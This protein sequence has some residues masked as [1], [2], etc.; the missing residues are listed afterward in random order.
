MITDLSDDFKDYLY[1]RAK[2]VVACVEIYSRSTE[3]ISSISS[4]GAA[5]ARFSN[6]CYNWSNSTGTYEYSAKITSFPS[7]N[8]YLTEQVNNA[9]ITLSNTKRGEG[10][11]SRFVLNNK[12]KGCWLVIR[13]LFPELPEESLIVWW[14]K[15][16]RPGRINNTEVVLEAT[17]EMGNYK[18]ELPLKTYSQPCP[19]TFGKDAC[20]GNQTLAE[21]SPAYQEAYANY[22][23]MGC[24]DRTS[25]TCAILSNTDY[26]QGQRLVAAT[27]QFSYVDPNAD[28][29]EVKRK[30]ISPVK[31]E[32][33]SSMN[34][35]DSTDVVPIAFGRCQ[36]AGHPFTWADTG[37][38]VKSLQAFCEGKISAFD[39]IR[40]RTYNI[41]ITQIVQ[42]LGDWGNVGTQ[43]LDTLFNGSSGYNSRLAYLELVTNG[44]SPTQV[45]DAPL[46]TAVIRGLEI[47]VPDPLG[48]Y[49]QVEY[50]NNPIHIVRYLLTD[51][52]YGRVPAYRMADA[53]HVIEAN[54]CDK[55]VEDRTQAESI[56][57]PTNEYNS[58]GVG[59]RRYRS[60]SRYTAYKDMWLRGE[61]GGE[62]PEFDEPEIRWFDPSAQYTVP[63]R[64]TVL[65]QLYTLN[66]A[67]QEKTS[68]LD[69][70]TK[71]LLPCFRGFISYNHH[72]EVEIR[73]RRPA[74]YSYIR[75]NVVAGDTN[76]PIINIAK[77]RSNFDG[78]LLIGVSSVNAEIRKVRGISYY[79]TSIPV[80]PTASGGLIATG[81][82]IDSGGFLID[83]LTG[84]TLTD[85]L[86]GESLTSGTS[87]TSPAI[88]YVDISGTVSDGAIIEL[89]IDSGSANFSV[90]YKCQG[91]ETL[92]SVTR[93]LT[94]YLNANPEFNSYLTAYILDE[95]PNRVW[96]RCEV[97]QL[98]LD[99]AIEFD[100]SSAEE[101]MRVQMVFENCGDLDST[102]SAQF[103]NIVADSFVWNDEYNDEI[104]AVSGKYT[105]AVDDFHLA[106]LLPRAAWDTIEL[107]GELNKE[108]LDLRFVDNYWQAAYITKA[109]AIEMIDG[110][111]PFTW[112]SGLSA[113]L[114]EMS[115]VVAVRHDSGDG[116]LNY[117]PVWITG[118]ELAIDTFQ[119]N[120]KGSLYFSSSFDFRVQPVEPLLTTTLNPDTAS[121]PP[122]L[123]TSGGSGTGSE[124]RYNPKSADYYREFQTSIYS[125][126]GNDNI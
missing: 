103:D 1:K 53:Q 97:G 30:K 9:T 73:T 52:R 80:I 115:D 16:L 67:L 110:N 81:V 27:G 99:R 28:P 82:T 15:C 102:S 43:T 96:I 39:F 113:L 49:T 3:D 68:L 62:F 117:L 54:Y 86:T 40:S 17:Q 4:P 23:T 38:E 31:T 10:S 121:V 2:Y 75:T 60:A 48:D 64:Q 94:A 46:V 34:D 90:G 56:L 89:S 105:S 91:I 18:V 120:L 8:K 22:G 37:T 36:L 87:T 26:F 92:N 101:V 123:G 95:L 69:F 74:D 114:L 108:E 14:G 35:A 88:S 59:F 122:T 61:I 19:L 119:V 41:N 25:N 98:I 79:P 5:L 29:K 85:T 11:A 20:L 104:N 116:V 109:T 124:P 63:P 106:E 77:W 58:Y 71:R 76:L 47:P 112:K 126:E 84:E 57:L 107:E 125:R 83:T 118:T 33:W 65:R 24:A 55:L 13:F 6:I 32:S 51:Y 93:M 72:A 7:V 111:L 100:H 50:S 12:I 66:G 21:K 44:S 78:Y 45:D 42:H 70:I